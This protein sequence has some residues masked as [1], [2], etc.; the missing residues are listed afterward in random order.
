[1][2]KYYVA[3]FYNND[4]VMPSVVFS[5]DIEEDAIKYAEIVSRA[6]GNKYGVMT[7]EN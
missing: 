7:F 1:M 6:D 2:K 3:R 4:C 5:T